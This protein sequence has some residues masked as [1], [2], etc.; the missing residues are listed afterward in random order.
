[1]PP[2][3]LLTATDMDTDPVAKWLVKRLKT[4]TWL[5]RLAAAGALLGGLVV[6]FLT[7]WFAY[8]IVYISGRGLNGL[9]GLTTSWHVDISHPIRL[10][11]AG[12]FVA[13]AFYT[14]WRTNEHYWGE[15]PDET[16][17]PFV[18]S[19]GATGALFQLA[20][21]P[22]TSARFIVDLLLTGPRLLGGALNLIRQAQHLARLDTEAAAT[23]I[24]TLLSRSHAVPWEELEA[25]GLTEAALHLRGVN[26]VVH[27]QRGVS[28]TNDLRSELSALLLDAD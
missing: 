9:L 26:G 27:L 25:L 21:H 2:T 7:F 18:R 5:Q 28:L 16:H 12:A 10:W 6:T 17:S 22:R 11:L 13:L 8:A 14:H 3:V 19:S 20:A 15:L 1:M 23:L 4:D 24:A